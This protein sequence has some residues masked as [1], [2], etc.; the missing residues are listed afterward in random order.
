MSR[1]PEVSREL[2]RHVHLLCQYIA[3]SSHVVE[4]SAEVVFL[5]EK[6]W[7]GAL[8]QYFFRG[9]VASLLED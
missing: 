8:R 5:A 7:D 1:R 2:Y 4:L 6:Q 9:A 3:K